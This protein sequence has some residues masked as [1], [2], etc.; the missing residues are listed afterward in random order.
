MGARTIRHQ[1]PTY[2]PHEHTRIHPMQNANERNKYRSR[3][4]SIQHKNAMCAHAD[5]DRI[6]IQHPP[7]TET[8]H[9]RYSLAL[10]L[11][12]SPTSAS[13]PDPFCRARS[14]AQS[15]L[16]YP[17]PLPP[18]RT[19]VDTLTWCVFAFCVAGTSWMGISEPARAK[20]H[21]SS[22]L[23]AIS[24]DM[25]GGGPRLHLDS[26][27]HALGGGWLHQSDAGRDYA[28]HTT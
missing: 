5:A 10:Q 1:T 8:I 12:T 28:A 26:S 27:S 19:Q 9:T 16:I 13:R 24:L 4:Q 15:A 7:Q 2:T 22:H 14:W 23:T 6:H 11:L 25:D 3:H 17:P 20:L 21:P 18:H